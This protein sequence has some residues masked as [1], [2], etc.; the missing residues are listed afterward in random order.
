MSSSWKEVRLNEITTKIGDGLHGTPKYDESGEYFFINGNNLKDGSIVITDKTKRA[1]KDEFFKHKKEL[2]N[3]TVLVSINGTIGNVALY[4]NEK[5]FLGKSACYINI[6][7]N[8]DLQ[9][10]RYYLV[11]KIFQ[12]HIRTF[13]TGTTIKN[14]SLK[15]IRNFK[16]FLPD[17]EIQRKISKILYDLDRKIEL[18]QQINQTLEA[19]AQALF[20][21]WFVDFD[22]V[23][24]KI[25]AK[26][27]GADAAGITLAAM[28]AISGQ[29]AE[30][31]AK[32]A[33]SEPERYAELK[34]TAELFPDAL[35]A[36]ELGEI[37]IGW[38][39][40][41]LK[42]CTSK[43]GSGSTPKGGK[44]AYVDN[45]I[46]LVRS[47]NIHD[48][49]FKWGGIVSITDEAAEKLK[50]VS[51]TRRDVLLNITGDSILRTCVVDP[52]VLPARVNQHVMIL[53]PI[54]LIPTHYLHQYIVRSEY[55]KYLL[56]FDAGGSRKAIT[57]GNLEEASILIPHND[58]LG[59]FA[60]IVA[61][62]FELKNKNNIQN[63]DLEN[64][65]DS[66]LPKLLS[67]EVSV[68]NV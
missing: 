5:V 3:H 15:T 12:N 45:G 66:L 49:S 54:N 63:R 32:M 17:V 39:V 34:A 58:I 62:I 10:I 67:G 43:I 59:K 46:K 21:S 57:K 8:I 38:E 11:S 64:L 51:L 25:A 55:K 24:A 31:L 56:G 42:D 65:R 36:S 7:P 23:K 14:V 35:E 60:D 4:N 2:N 33:Q 18:N 27:A 13:A 1:S 53:R 68:E 61:P 6:K 48:S 19:M 28:E 26:A 41:Q 40:N 22:P 52:S 16:L 29:N 44:S 20:K 37:P 50:N 47:Q 9:Y 30:A